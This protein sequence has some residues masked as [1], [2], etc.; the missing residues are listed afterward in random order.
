ME[1]YAYA[2]LGWIR[3]PPESIGSRQHGTE[4]AFQGI[5][6][7]KPTASLNLSMDFHDEPTLS[8]C[9][10]YVSANKEESETPQPA[11][12]PGVLSAF[13]KYLTLS[14]L[15]SILLVK[16]TITTGSCALPT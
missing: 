3:G 16:V 7:S 13:A 12:I 4:R 5:G 15:S 9:I 2:L 11:L 6:A 14:S 10:G 1:D 8:L